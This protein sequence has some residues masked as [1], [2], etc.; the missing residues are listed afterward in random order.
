MAFDF[1]FFSFDALA[2]GG[3]HEVIRG[4]YL[5]TGVVRFAYSEHHL[6]FFMLQMIL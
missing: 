6:G 1:L 2:W 4:D 5:K 3:R